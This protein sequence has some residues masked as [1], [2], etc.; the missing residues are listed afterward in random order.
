MRVKKV[1]SI[2]L[3]V[4]FLLYLSATL[5]YC[6]VAGGSSVKYIVS[7][8]GFSITVSLLIGGQHFYIRYL[9]QKGD[10]HGAY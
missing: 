6:L 2:V 5:F 4:V 9:E 3:P 7:A 8:L 10:K 1:L